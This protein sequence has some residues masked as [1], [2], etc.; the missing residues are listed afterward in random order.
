[1]NDDL[2]AKCSIG[3]I[4]GIGVGKTT[5]IKM[6]VRALQSHDVPAISLAE[7]LSEP[8]LKMS[9]EN[10][11]EWATHFQTGM[12]TLAIVRNLLASERKRTH[13]VIIERPIEENPI[14]AV[15]KYLET[16]GK[17]LDDRYMSQ[18]YGP[19]VEFSRRIKLEPIACDANNDTD[20]I[21]MLWGSLSTLMTRINSRAREAELLM[22]PDYMKTLQVLYF[23][24]LVLNYPRGKITVVDWNEHCETEEQLQ[25]NVLNVLKTVRRTFDDSQTVELNIETFLGLP[26]ESQ[27]SEMK[28]VTKS[29]FKRARLNL[30]GE[31][32]AIYRHLQKK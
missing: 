32:P 18:F 17:G 11:V 1:M 15:C 9:I 30:K 24:W 8:H 25:D 21:V 7:W 22:V 12:V 26:F 27:T 4:G 29:L 3:V 2:P 31:V 14:F 19:W 16:N 10:P 5:F 23:V 6:A 20:C 13:T 28:R